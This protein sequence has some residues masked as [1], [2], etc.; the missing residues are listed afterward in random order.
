MKISEPINADL[1]L[2]AL[3]GKTKKQ[4][5]EELVKHLASCKQE[6]DSDELLK[7]LIERE[8]LGSTGIG[9]GIALPHPRD[10]LSKPPAS[11]VITTCFTENPV[12][13]GAIDDLPVSVLFLLVSPTVK[14]HLHLLS[15]LS[16]CI[17]DRAFVDFLHSHPDDNALQAQVSEFEKRLDTL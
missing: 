2:P 17:R 11:P 1:M 4:V 8:K 5:L 12:P 3:K 13:F 16:Y 7:V 10:P 6:I 15:R 9:N 14:H